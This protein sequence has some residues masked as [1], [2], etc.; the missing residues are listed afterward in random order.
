MPS[1]IPITSPGRLRWAAAGPPPAS[2]GSQRRTGSPRGFCRQH[3][4]WPSPGLSPGSR[5]R[6]FQTCPRTSQSP[7]P[8]PLQWIRHTWRQSGQL[9]LGSPSLPIPQKPAGNT[10]SALRTESRWPRC[11]HKRTRRLR[12]WGVLVARDSP[13]YFFVLSS[14]KSNIHTYRYVHQKYL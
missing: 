3:S 8:R 4:A 2:S 14:F 6:G 1:R 10:R 12:E 13:E 11:R 7:T 9:C 5:S